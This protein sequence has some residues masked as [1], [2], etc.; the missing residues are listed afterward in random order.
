MFQ[1][2]RESY[3]SMRLLLHFTLNCEVQCSYIAPVMV[4]HY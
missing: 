3:V 2:T 1:W 4:G